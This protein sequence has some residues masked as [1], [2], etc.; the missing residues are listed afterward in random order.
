M[1]FVDKLRL[2]DD[3]AEGARGVLH[4]TTSVELRIDH[5]LGEAGSKAT[6]MEEVRQ[7]DI[8]RGVQLLVLS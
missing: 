4:D 8:R 5:L 1:G 7:H 3:W 6:L 2:A